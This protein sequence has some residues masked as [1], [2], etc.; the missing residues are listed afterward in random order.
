MK[1]TYGK[2]AVTLKGLKSS[3]GVEEGAI[4][5]SNKLEQNGIVLQFLEVGAKTSQTQNPPFL[6]PILDQYSYF[7][8]EPKPLPPYRSHD[9]SINLQP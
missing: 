3:G 8:E 4:N 2:K 6:Q 9:H 1:F 7:F 5:K